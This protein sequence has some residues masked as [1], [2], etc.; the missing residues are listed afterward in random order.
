MHG[1]IEEAKLMGYDI[2]EWA[3]ND[4]MT[5]MTPAPYISMDTEIPINEWTQLL[6]PYNIE[7]YAGIDP[8]F[9]PN[10]TLEM[11]KGMSASFYNQGADA[12]YFHNL[13][14]LDTIKELIGVVGGQ[15]SNTEKR[16]IWHE[17]SSADNAY[18]GKR[19]YV[20]SGKEKPLYLSLY[21]IN[22]TPEFPIEKDEYT[23]NFKTGYIINE[24][25]YVY[26][27]SNSFKD[28]YVDNI[29]IE[30]I[31]KLKESIVKDSNTFVYKLPINPKK[32]IYSISFGNCL[33]KDIRIKIFDKEQ[34][35]TN[36]I[37][38]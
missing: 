33:L 1:Y 16:L 31:G 38:E 18:K 7:V 3:K 5:S 27:S 36:I 19:D 37:L 9:T 11:Y 30:Y 8:L 14:R 24:Y 32:N 15:N 17:C 29:K 20:I 22:V 4:W 6:H 12:I 35:F 2:K 34:D 25:A 13:Y 10:I 23:Y 26:L 21:D 28:L